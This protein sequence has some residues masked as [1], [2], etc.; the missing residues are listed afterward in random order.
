[1]RLSQDLERMLY[2]LVSLA[3]CFM[4]HFPLNIDWVFATFLWVSRKTDKVEITLGNYISQIF[5]I[6][7]LRMLLS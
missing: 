1:M 7:T 2:S 5:Q 6:P 4:G 3:V